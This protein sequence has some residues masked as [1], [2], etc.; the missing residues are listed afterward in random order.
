MSDAVTPPSPTGSYCDETVLPG[1][2]PAPADN[3]TDDQ[4]DALWDLFQQIGRCWKNVRRDSANQRSSWLEFITVKCR[5]QQSYVGEYVNALRVVQ[6][7]IETHGLVHAY[8]RLFLNHQF[9]DGIKQPPRTRLDHAKVYVVNE[10]IGVQVVAG[11]FR[12]FGGPNRAY[13]YNG[14]V[15]GSRYNRTRR[16]R[17]YRPTQEGPS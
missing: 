10:F 8:E 15:R 1:L 17:A 2:L 13:N 16:V 9:P 14:F 4:R 11:G 5:G 3:L 7:L 12:G 6:D